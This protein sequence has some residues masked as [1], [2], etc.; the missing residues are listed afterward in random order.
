MQQQQ[1]Q[2]DSKLSNGH[3]NGKE[4]GDVAASTQDPVSTS[5]AV[6]LSQT[7]VFHDYSIFEEV[8]KTV[9]EIINACLT[10]NLVAN[11]NLIYTLL[12]NREV[13]EPFL[14]SPAFQDIIIN[15]ET[16]LTYFSNRIEATERSLSV[17]EV[18]DIIKQSSLQWPSEKLKVSCLF[19]L[20]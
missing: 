20:F 3:V 9:L 17:E 1:Q 4:G 14:S 2:A 15:I 16:V 12:Y 7:D 19:F 10:K 5:V 13:F 11:S 18:Y 8:L 6:D